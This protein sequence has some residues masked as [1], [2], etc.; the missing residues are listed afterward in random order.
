MF[1]QFQ[2]GKK[3][4]LLRKVHIVSLPKSQKKEV[5]SMRAVKWKNVVDNHSLNEYLSD[6]KEGE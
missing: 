2:S 1:S 6:E 3:G 4:D 5:D